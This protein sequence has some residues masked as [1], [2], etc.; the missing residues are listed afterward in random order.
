[1]SFMHL[2]F[3]DN[4]DPPIVKTFEIA[5]RSYYLCRNSSVSFILI[6]LV[7]EVYV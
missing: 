6:Y 2:K 3:R 7:P 1:M 5:I 4:F